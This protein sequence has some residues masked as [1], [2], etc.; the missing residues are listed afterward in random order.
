V[1][2][3]GAPKEEKEDI[4]QMGVQ[5]KGSNI[6]KRGRKVQGSPSTRRLFIVERS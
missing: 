3:G 5:E 1:G 6:R 4:M 2:F